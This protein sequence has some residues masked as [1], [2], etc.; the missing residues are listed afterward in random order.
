VYWYWDESGVDAA[1]A[2]PNKSRGLVRSLLNKRAFIQAKLR[3]LQLELDHHLPPVPDPVHAA[4]PEMS[5]FPWARFREETLV[6]SPCFVIVVSQ[7]EEW[8]RWWHLFQVRIERLRETV[9]Q[10]RQRSRLLNRAISLLLTPAC[11][12]FQF[13]LF[14]RERAWSLLHG[15]HPPRRNAGIC[16]PAFAK[17]G[18]FPTTRTC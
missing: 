16:R 10:L 15:S 7:V 4:I 3:S 8:E 6:P 9:R 17:V 13:Q 11:P 1:L 14:S 18:G 2:Q 12:P 5:I